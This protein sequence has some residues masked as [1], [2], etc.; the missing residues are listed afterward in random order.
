MKNEE[1]KVENPRFKEIK[2]TDEL[3]DELWDLQGNDNFSIHSEI[4]RINEVI[5]LIT[6]VHIFKGGEINP[7]YLLEQITELS[8]LINHFKRLKAPYELNKK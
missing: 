7:D 3:I 4:E 2:F 6:T 5:G 1:K 8:S